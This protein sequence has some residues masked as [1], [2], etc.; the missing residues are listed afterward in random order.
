MAGALLII[1]GPSGVGK[2]TICDELV[3]R[4]DAFLSVSATTRPQR[5][6]EV[7]GVDY[8][9]I[10][11]EEFERRLARGEFLEFAKVYGDQYYGT[12]AGPV[13]D[14]LAAGRTVILEIEIAG[15]LQVVKRFPEALTIY[16]LAPTAEDQKARLEGR[17]RDSAEAMQERLTKADGEIGWA[18]DCGAY[19]HFLVN[20]TVE[21]TVDEII[22][23]M[24]ESG[25][26]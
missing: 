9:F 1:S 25:S 10:S 15:T 3:R 11:T 6:N 17:R 22:R 13:M 26:R 12:P 18:H 21:V 8:H 19:R 24:R 7:D 23:L 20:D 14:A 5:A 2:T 4:L 16:I